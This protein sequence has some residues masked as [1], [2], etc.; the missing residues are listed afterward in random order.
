MYSSWSSFATGVE[1]DIVLSTDPALEVITDRSDRIMPLIYCMDGLIT[2]KEA[3][4]KPRIRTRILLDSGVS[5]ES[6]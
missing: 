4:E 5:V 3:Y 6:L 1:M 2:L